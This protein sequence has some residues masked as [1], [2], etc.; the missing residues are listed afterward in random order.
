MGS[1]DV[2]VEIHPRELRFLG[3]CPP[4]RSLIPPPPFQPNGGLEFGDS[5][6]TIHPW[7][8]GLICL[9]HWPLIMG[10][11]VIIRWRVSFRLISHDAAMLGSDWVFDGTGGSAC[12]RQG[13]TIHA[14]ISNLHLRMYDSQDNLITCDCLYQPWH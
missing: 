1:E 7:P 5:V 14:S 10:G 12:L 11:S 3:T 13:L 4:S 2:L 6:A 8:G 9:M